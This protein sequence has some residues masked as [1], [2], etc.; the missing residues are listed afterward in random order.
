[1]PV[2]G[3]ELPKLGRG[4]ETVPE[5]VQADEL[6][7]EAQGDVAEAGRGGLAGTTDNITKCKYDN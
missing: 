3:N 4:Y 7:A 1:M 6:R 5:R 2:Y